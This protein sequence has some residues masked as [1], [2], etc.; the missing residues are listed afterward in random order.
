MSTPRGI[1]SAAGVLAGLAGLAVSRAATMALTLRASPMV[2]VAELV[3]QYVPGPVAEK[4]IAILGHWDKP[5]LV[6]VIFLLLVALFAYAGSLAATSWWKPI[7]V[8]A[9]LGG[10]GLWA[11]LSRYD[12]RPIDVL[13]VAAGTVTWIV[14]L[15]FLTD[16]LRAATED[17]ARHERE[18]TERTPEQRG[19][20]RRTFLI[21]AGVVA[22]LASV[23]GIFGERLGRRRRHVE[24]SRR[25]LKLPITN[26]RPASSARVDVDGISRWRTANERFYLIHT[27]IAP[28]AI[29]PS[30][31]KLRIHGLV[32]RELSLTYQELIDREI[33]EDW[34]TL[35]CVSNPV[36]GPLIGNAWW[37]GVRLDALL[38]EA[39][40]RSGADAVLQ[41]SW[42]GWTCG[43]PLNVLVEPER[44]AML[45]I[46]MN[47][48]PLPIDHGFPVRTIVPGLY[49]FVSACKWVTDIEV[50]RFQDFT[51]YWTDKGWSERG[52]VKI[53]SRI[54]VPR[55]GD[56]VRAGPV[57]V[58][59]AAWA[60]TIGIRAVE[61][62]LDGAA[63]KQAQLGTVPNNDT[64][65]Q[66]VAT[67][68][69]EEGDHRLR[70]RAVGA[71]GQ[72]QTG[73]ERD[74]R[75]DGATGWHEVEFSAKGS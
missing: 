35:N 5:V 41:T 43:T 58:G 32:E 29:E 70:V 48:E 27:A 65:R 17:T 72:V 64:W 4:A 49:G 74:V 10:I 55:N 67:V 30:E 42:D 34:I 57:R 71:D 22:V 8:F 1:W 47:G 21:R 50:S 53:A 46:A 60:Q 36:G 44:N 51:A 69:L 2:A 61:Y 7:I 24:M 37:S 28:P 9:V 66:W 20:T 14:V 68:D 52:P 15:S 31:W 38:A 19:H 54:E 13:P 16:P 6:A 33:T 12:A 11:V 56:D 26:P 59:G 62:S 25:L 75:P 3:V 63:W 45:A 73:V 39:G 23:V 40:V 18:G